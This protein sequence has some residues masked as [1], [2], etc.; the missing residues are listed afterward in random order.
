MPVTEIDETHEDNPYLKE[1]EQIAAET[2]AEALKD[3][4]F[5]AIYCSEAPH[6]IQTAYI[7]AS[8][9]EC[10]VVIHPTLNGFHPLALFKKVGA[11]R[12][13]ARD[14]YLNSTDQ[15]ICWVVHHNLMNIIGK[16][17]YGIYKTIPVLSYIQLDYDETGIHLP[18]NPTCTP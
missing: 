12:S 5:S 18:K 10:P 15:N 17:V 9:H 7:L 11:I 14:L 13:L 4:N 16:R 1:E 3:A 8:Y 6:A 2:V